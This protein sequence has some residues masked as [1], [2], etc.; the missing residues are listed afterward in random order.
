MRLQ[1][2]RRVTCWFPMFCKRPSFAVQNVVFRHVIGGIL[3]RERPPIAVHPQTF[4]I[5]HESLPRPRRGGKLR[6]TAGGVSAANVTCGKSKLLQLSPKGANGVLGYAVAGSYGYAVPN[7]RITLNL[8][9]VNAVRPLRGRYYVRIH[10]AS[11]ASLHMRLSLIGRLR[12]PATHC[13]HPKGL[14]MNPNRCHALKMRCQKPPG[15]Y[16]KPCA[17]ARPGRQKAKFSTL[18]S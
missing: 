10:T 17:D 1:T 18:R 6:L 12:R 13:C 15:C 8:T 3:R 5:E 7:N 9:T 14:R 2:F 16:T 11:S 4:W